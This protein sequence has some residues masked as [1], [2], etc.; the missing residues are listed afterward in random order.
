MS[1]R[2]E[3]IARR[4]NWYSDPTRLIANAD[5]FLAQVMARGTAEEIVDVQRHFSTEQ[6]RDAYRHAP[7]GLFGNRAWAYW[8]LVLLD[9]PHLPKPE[10]FPGASR[11]DWRKTE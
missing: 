2:L 10:R 9:N 4:V 5:L 3:E 1:A 7:P 6:F 11:F 8:G